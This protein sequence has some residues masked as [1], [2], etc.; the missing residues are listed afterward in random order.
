M[1]VCS[2]PFI[3]GCIG[4][5]ENFPK[6]RGRDI[7]NSFCIREEFL[8]SLEFCKLFIEEQGISKQN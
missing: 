2:H 7:Y 3:V 4:R 5:R 8:N 1:S 6:R